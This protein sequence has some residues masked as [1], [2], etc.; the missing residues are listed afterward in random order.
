MVCTVNNSPINPLMPKM[1][2][3]ICFET[4]VIPNREIIEE[5]LV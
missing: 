5:N 2:L 3:F 1:S 4:S